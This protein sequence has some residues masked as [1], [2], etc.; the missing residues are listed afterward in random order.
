MYDPPSEPFLVHCH[1]PKTGG[2]AL[3]QRFLFQRYGHQNVHL[4]Y[5][6]I[7]ERSSRL[8]IRHRTRAM[9]SFAA[10]GHI[11]FGFLD[12][13]YPDAIYVSVFRDPV[14]RFLSFINFMM[15]TEDHAARGRLMAGT[16]NSGEPDPEDLVQAALG[17][18]K[19]V[20]I[21]GNAQCRLASGNAR[22]SAAPACGLHL[23]AAQ[24]NIANPRYVIG[25]QSHLP[26][27][28]ARLWRMTG[29]SAELAGVPE[30]KQE[31]EKR[32]PRRLQAA[33]LSPR[34]LDRVRSIN[35]LDL[36][37]VDGVR[38]AIATGMTNAA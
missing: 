15:M 5:R 21:H 24:Q 20:R 30:P 32:L 10:S 34:T 2:S 26:A 13:L 36:H 35:D 4:M 3:N 19:I 31:L 28:L 23:A 29:S 14:E 37:L 17:D 18:E 12:S 9:R 27:F 16:D 25:L 38:T 11:P 22:L 6:F 1:M 7:F 33:N 8:P